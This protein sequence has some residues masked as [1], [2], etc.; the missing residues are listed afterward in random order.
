MNYENTRSCLNRLDLKEMVMFK[1]ASN[2]ANI[3]DNPLQIK[4]D[5]SNIENVK[6]KHDLNL[7]YIQ[8]Y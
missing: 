5:K 2:N 3:T 7:K 4:S 6:L 1:L 8:F